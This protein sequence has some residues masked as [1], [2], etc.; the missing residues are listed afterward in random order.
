V[1]TKLPCSTRPNPFLKGTTLNWCHVAY[2]KAN[3]I[4][5]P[6]LAD[7]QPK[8]AVSQLYGAYHEKE[9]TSQRALYLIDKNG[10]IQYAHISP[11]AINPGA[12]G[13][14]EKLKEIEPR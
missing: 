13:V 9:G 8:G 5:F 12:D 4:H 11:D 14:L 1:E 6:L 3:N 10:I 7:F 2:A